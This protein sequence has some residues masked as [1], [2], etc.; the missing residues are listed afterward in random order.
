VET[1]GKLPPCVQL[2]SFHQS[3]ARDVLYQ[4]VPREGRHE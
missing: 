1:N 3:E 2:T 4:V